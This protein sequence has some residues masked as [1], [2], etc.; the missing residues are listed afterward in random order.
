MTGVFL[1]SITKKTIPSAFWQNEGVP[2]LPFGK[3]KRG[4]KAMSVAEAVIREYPLVTSDVE[5]PES[6]GEPM[7]EIKKPHA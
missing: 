1:F 3:T 5:Y 2:K 7:G 6:D 4:I